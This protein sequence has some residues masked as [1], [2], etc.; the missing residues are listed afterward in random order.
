MFEKQM[1]FYPGPLATKIRFKNYT[2]MQ[3]KLPVKS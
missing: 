1:K 3:Q 2:Q